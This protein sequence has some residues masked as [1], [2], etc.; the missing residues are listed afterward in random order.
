MWIKN[1]ST[2]RFACNETEHDKVGTVALV[3]VDEVHT[4]G[5]ERGATLEV[6]LARMK[7]VSR[8]TEV[9]MILSLPPIASRRRVA[10]EMEKTFELALAALL[11]ARDGVEPSS[12]FSLVGRPVVCRQQRLTISNNNISSPHIDYNGPASSARRLQRKRHVRWI[13]PGRGGVLSC[14]RRRCMLAPNTPSADACR[15]VFS[16]VL[17]VPSRDIVF[18]DIFVFW[19]K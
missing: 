6:I 13:N 1:F 8:S 19:R 18:G 15:D 5:E 11:F 17:D 7:M 3:L 4:I 14:Q 10:L 2:R 16:V 12:M 9:G